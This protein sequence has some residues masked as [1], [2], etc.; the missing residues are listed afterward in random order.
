MHCVRDSPRTVWTLAPAQPAL[1]GFAGGHAWVERD[2]AGKNGSVWPWLLS[3]YAQANFD[4][5]RRWHSCLRPRRCW[6]TEEDIQTYGIG[7]IG[8]LFD[9]DLSVHTSCGAIS[10][11]RGAAA[12][13]DIYG[14]IRRRKPEEQ[15]RRRRKS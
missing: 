13:L 1:Q 10:C 11:R 3:F 7:S 4:I 2:F 9:A 14:M 6:P 8:E 12:V 15:P 5:P